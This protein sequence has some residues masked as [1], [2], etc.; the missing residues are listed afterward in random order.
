MAA[1]A[2]I[3]SPARGLCAALDGPGAPADYDFALALRENLP[4]SVLANPDKVLRLIHNPPR[5]RASQDSV[6]A[7]G[8]GAG[9]AADVSDSLPKGLPPV[10][11]VIVSDP[12]TPFMKSANTALPEFI[13]NSRGTGPWSFGK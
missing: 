5:A 11:F 3:R 2:V 8:T 10:P 9:A 4:V 13:S 1:G 6:P 7:P 12:P